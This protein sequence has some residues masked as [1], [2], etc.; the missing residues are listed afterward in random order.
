MKLIES[1]WTYETGTWDDDALAYAN[2]KRRT[3]VKEIGMEIL[4]RSNG[5]EVLQFVGGPTGHESY[6]MDDMLRMVDE[7]PDTFC[8]CAG[9]MNSWPVCEVKVADVRKF[10]EEEGKR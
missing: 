1:L 4:T 6:Y 7:W 3:E 10:L 2:I 5:Q 8:I 9:T